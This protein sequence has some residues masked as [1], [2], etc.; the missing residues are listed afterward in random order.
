MVHF[1]VWV[2]V[3]GL[4]LLLHNMWVLPLAGQML[5]MNILMLHVVVVVTLRLLGQF[6]YLF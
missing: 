6:F 2:V 3:W 1:Y 4:W 5:R